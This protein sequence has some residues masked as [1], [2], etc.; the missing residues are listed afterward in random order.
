MSD[1]KSRNQ[2]EISVILNQSEISPDQT[3]NDGLNNESGD[4]TGFDTASTSNLLDN[5]AIANGA[6]PVPKIMTTPSTNPFDDPDLE[7]KD[8]TDGQ[9]AVRKFTKVP[10]GKPKKSWWFRVNSEFA[11]AVRGIL[12]DEL[13]TSAGLNGRSYIVSDSI[14][15]EYERLVTRVPYTS[16]SIARARLESGSFQFVTAKV[17]RT[18][19]GSPKR[20][21]RR[22]REPN[23]SPWSGTRAPGLTPSPSRRRI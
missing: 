11:R 19:R 17:V 20:R 14:R 6:K 9:L 4:F 7:L 22:S 8:V 16:T 10:I 2:E 5:Q 13:D 23:G 21:R 3:L 18:T 12:T 15:N 1:E